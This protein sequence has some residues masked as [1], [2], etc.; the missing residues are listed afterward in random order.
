V[1]AR[2]AVVDRLPDARHG[3]EHGR[4]HGRQILLEA[5]AVGVDE[6]G[7]GGE[8]QIVHDPLVHVPGR[9]HRKEAVGIGD[10]QYRADFAHIAEQ[11]AVR[12]HHTL[13]LGGGATGVDD[14]QQVVGRDGGD[15]FAQF[16]RTLLPPRLA[17]R[18]H[19]RQGQHVRQ[20]G[21]SLHRDQLLQTRQ[22][23]AVH[24]QALG[25]AVVLDEDRARTGMPQDVADFER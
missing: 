5:A 18:Q 10:V 16:I 4:R 2:D 21:L 8:R 19:R 22:F 6:L 17:A 3:G 15:H 1:R 24:Q 20:R 14:R 7:A 13:G 25:S 11:V 12:Q 23:A 9:Q